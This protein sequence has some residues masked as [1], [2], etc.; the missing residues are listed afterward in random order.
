MAFM[1]SNETEA[2]IHKA[3]ADEKAVLA[4]HE[5]FKPIDEH[6]RGIF[7]KLRE[8]EAMARSSRLAAREAVIAEVGLAA[9]IAE[10]PP[11]K[12]EPKKPT[13]PPPGKSAPAPE[14]AKPTPA[15]PKPPTPA[16]ESP[17]APEPAK[18]EP[19]KPVPQEM[20]VKPEPAKPIPL[21][22]A[23]KN[24]FT[25]SSIATPTGD[26]QVSVNGKPNGL[27][28]SLEAKDGIVYGIEASGATWAF[29]DGE[30]HKVASVGAATAPGK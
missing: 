22:D 3:I 2:L 28:K 10:G 16:P 21:T 26:F 6:H 30:W 1:L 7:L 13:E 12:A 5:A 20:P 27:A 17:K 25:L 14:P 4:L 9:S 15:E 18:P 29:T 23:Q 8:V 24:V 19:S 11:E